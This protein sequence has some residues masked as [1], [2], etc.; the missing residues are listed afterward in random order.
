MLPAVLGVGAWAV[1]RQ[2]STEIA[3]L[4]GQGLNY[5]QDLALNRE[6]RKAAERR[7]GRVSKKTRGRGREREREREIKR[8]RQGHGRETDIKKSTRFFSFSVMTYTSSNFFAVLWFSER[9]DPPRK[10]VCKAGIW[11]FGGMRTLY[12]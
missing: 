4:A 6:R 11:Q 12:G 1:N 7:K 3:M 9:I 8:V 5:E 10:V 2:P